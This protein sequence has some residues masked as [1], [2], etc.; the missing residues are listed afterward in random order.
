MNAPSKGELLAK[1]AEREPKM[2]HQI[3]IFENEEECHIFSAPE[4]WDLMC[5]S[6]LR[7]LIDPN[8]PNDQARLCLLRVL[9]GLDHYRGHVEARAA[10]V[11]EARRTLDTPEIR[12]AVEAFRTH[13]QPL[14]W[15]DEPDIPF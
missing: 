7:I 10:A 2:F 3:D 14:P 12:A 6:Q 15:D 1:Y 5:G 11:K 4:S 8:F 9:E 13:N